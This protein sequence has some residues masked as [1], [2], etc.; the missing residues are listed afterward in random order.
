MCIHSFISTHSLANVGERGWE[1]SGIRQ[2]KE[3]TL[4][5]S[6]GGGGRAAGLPSTSRPPRS[7]Q[8]RVCSRC[9][10]APPRP[11][12]Y[13]FSKCLGSNPRCTMF[14]RALSST[15]CALGFLICKCRDDGA[16]WRAAPRGRPAEAQP[17]SRAGHARKGCLGAPSPLWVPQG[18]SGRLDLPS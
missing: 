15:S 16:Y 2:R 17:P 13:C 9:P 7:A 14:G 11:P 6:W 10:P 8:L 1:E 4:S 3:G 12:H 5:A 18:S